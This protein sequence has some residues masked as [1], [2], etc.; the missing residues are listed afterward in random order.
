MVQ[1]TKSPLQEL[2][3]HEDVDLPPPAYDSTFATG[4]HPTTSPG[5]START[6]DDRTIP[7]HISHLFLGPRN[8]EN[9]LGRNHVPSQ[10]LQAIEWRQRGKIIESWDPQLSDPMTL[11]DFIRARAM[12]PPKIKLRC[13]GMHQETLDRSGTVFENGQSVHKRAGE[14]MNVVDF[15]FTIDLSNILD[16]PANITHI[17]LR[18]AQPD[19][20]A[21]RGTHLERFAASYAPQKSRASHRPSHQGYET[22]LPS[23]A[24][25]VLE[26]GRVETYRERS[27]RAAWNTYRAQKGIPGWI[28]PQD[29]PDFWQ[30]R[31]K[32]KGALTLGG[33]DEGVVDVEDAGATLQQGR[34]QAAKPNLREWCEAYC[35]APGLLREFHLT[36]GLYGW[37]CEGVTKAITG[38]ILS[39][40]HPANHLTVSWDVSPHTVI[41][42]PDNV[43]SR[44]LGNGFIYFLSWITLIYPLI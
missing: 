33:A 23:A 28:K 39:T 22:L 18:A 12:T 1:D 9:L 30:G 5:P 21:H 44:A 10:E 6:G 27:D 38:A 17:H 32:G 25:G 3:F 29:I 36:T 11:Y 31:H 15:D 2:S 14:T 41:V 20:P 40:G 13:L 42:R 8:A 43:L 16:H 7:E 24:A 34:D 19:V 4:S 35:R 37:D 26:P